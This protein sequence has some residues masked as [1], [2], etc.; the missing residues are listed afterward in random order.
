MATSNRRPNLYIVGAPKS[1]TTALVAYLKQHPDVFFSERK[2][3]GYFGADLQY[4]PLAVRDQNHAEYLRH[5]ADW[6][7]EKWAGE[8]SV[9]YLFSETAAQEIKDFSPEA[10]IVIMLRNPVEVMYSNYYQLVFNGN[11]DLPTFE[12]ALAAE[13]ERKQGRRIPRTN[14][15]VNALFYRDTVKYA[16]QVARYFDV[17]GR[18]RVHVIIFDDF[19]ADNAASYRRLLAFLALDTSFQPSFEIVNPNK[20]VKNIR[21]RNALKNPVFA[22]L[23]QRFPT[24]AHRA[25][26]FFRRINTQY[27]ERPPMNAELRQTLLAEYRPEVERLG[28]LLGRDLLHWIAVQPAHSDEMMHG[29]RRR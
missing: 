9:W 3:L 10:R 7:D 6:G 24:I 15:L 18:E 1:G 11:E 5:F 29:E 21:L 27:A 23:A 28:V 20:Q 25:I 14:M 26:R 2:E 8:G 22:A 17:F 19:K 12:A 16:D 13:A 4:T